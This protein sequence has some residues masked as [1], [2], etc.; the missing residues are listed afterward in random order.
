MRLNRV[1]ASAL[2]GTAM[3]SA[4]A[5]QAPDPLTLAESVR[6]EIRVGW[7]SSD[8]TR[9]EAALKT[10]DRATVLYP[11]DALLHHYLGY[12]VYRHLQLQPP[13]LDE[14]RR[15]LLVRGL[16][17]LA[18][19]NRLTPMAESHI[20]RWSLMAQTITDAGSAMGVLGP[21][22]E[23]LAKAMRLGKDNPRVW[24]VNG[25]GTFFTPE[26]WGGGAQASLEQ[27]KKAEALY[28]GD[29]P[30]KA[31]PDWGRA[32]THAWL[33]IVHQRLGHA[34]ESRRAYQEALRLEP[35]FLWVKD[36]LLPGLEK[37]I[38]PFP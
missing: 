31:M 19:A 10:A 27:L 2:L 18:A 12:A 24:L 6:G 26:M 16:E 17:A 1:L 11:K 22:Q 9:V 23:E 15:A 14:P 34:E 30:G 21:M 13:P 20:L 29:R 38:Q 33:G 4:L 35:G 5:A 25:A 36:V 28:A 8:R 37:G 32:E 3:A 7:L